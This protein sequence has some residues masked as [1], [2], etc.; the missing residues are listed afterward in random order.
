MSEINTLL[1]HPSDGTIRDCY[2]EVPA[3]QQEKYLK[4]TPYQRLKW[5]DEARRF[6]LLARA[7]MRDADSARVREEPPQ[8]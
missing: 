3:E 1:W 5:L 7:G 4:F 2:Y 8:T 6:T